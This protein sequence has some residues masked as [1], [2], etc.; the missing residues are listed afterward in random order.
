MSERTTPPPPAPDW[1][2]AGAGSLVAPEVSR[3]V[4]SILDGVEREASQLRAD[5]R[6]EARRYLEHARRHVDGLVAER[7]TRIAGLSDE[8][9]RRAQVVLGRLEEA[10]PVREGFDNLVR[11]LGD[12]AERLAGEIEELHLG[13]SVA[14]PYWSAT[15]GAVDRAGGAPVPGN[16]AGQWDATP[17]PSASWSGY[18]PP[19]PA[20]APAHDAPAVRASDGYEPPRPAE[21]APPP[22]HDPHASWGPP[23]PPSWG[24]DPYAPPPTYDHAPYP[25]A[26]AP[27]PY[28]PNPGYDA[29]GYPAAAYPTSHP[30]VAAAPPSGDAE[31]R[32]LA[33]QM[34]GSGNTRAQI[35]QHLREQFGFEHTGPLLDEIFGAGSPD[36]SRVPWT[37]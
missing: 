30:A 28:P 3:R 7:Q 6:E 10:G 11:S 16:Q 17:P 36:D 5:A 2:G 26:P 1:P 31:V 14:P 37:V 29:Y 18:A 25:P 15:P 23:P 8:L 12:A 34:A 32:S 27:A 13:Q 20:S 19:Y 21:Y 9:I 24:V 35:A 4:R 33:L 22:P